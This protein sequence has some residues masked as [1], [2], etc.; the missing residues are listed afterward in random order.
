MKAK[1]L[2]LAIALLFAAGIKSQTVID[3]PYTD[4]RY[5]ATLFTYNLAH[6]D[7]VQTFTMPDRRYSGWVECHS[8]S[9]TGSLTGSI[10]LFSTTNTAWAYYNHYAANDSLVMDA[11][12]E[13]YRFQINADDGSVKNFQVKVRVGGITGGTLVGKI[14]LQRTQ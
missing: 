10:K 5:E 14:V 12:S 3:P 6:G 7:T 2:F 8:S 4:A 13:S 9:V 1:V 11:A